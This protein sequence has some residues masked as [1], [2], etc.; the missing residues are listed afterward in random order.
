MSRLT[1][2]H[3]YDKDFA[4]TRAQARSEDEIAMLTGKA[5]ATELQR[6]NSILPENF[7]STAKVNWDMLTVGTDTHS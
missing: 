6:K 7:W 3:D 2:V 1:S 5:S 4:E